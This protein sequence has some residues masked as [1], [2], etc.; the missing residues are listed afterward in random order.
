MVLCQLPVPLCV[1]VI[2]TI[3]GGIELINICLMDQVF[4]RWECSFL[5]TTSNGVH[6]PTL[7]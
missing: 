3:F 2:S 5:S 6:L 1:H 7:Y 4:G